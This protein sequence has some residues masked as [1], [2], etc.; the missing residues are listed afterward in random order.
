MAVYENSETGQEGLWTVKWT[1]I[2]KRELLNENK[3]YVFAYGQYLCR[4]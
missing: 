1:E 3:N 4:E 2:I